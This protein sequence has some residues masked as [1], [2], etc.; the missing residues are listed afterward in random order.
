MSKRNKIILS[1]WILVYVIALFIIH[2]TYSFTTYW[3]EESSI[4]LLF[5][6]LNIVIGLIL[7]FAINR[8]IALP[9]YSAISVKGVTK[10]VA[11]ASALKALLCI[12]TLY[13]TNIHPS[14][15]LVAWISISTFFF[16]LHKNMK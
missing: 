8:K 15:H 14:I 1:I 7:Y 2:A 3:V 10:I 12:C 16:T 5:S 4:I 6:L 13:F 9:Q 11:Y